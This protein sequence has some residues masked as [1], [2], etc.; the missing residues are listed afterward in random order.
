MKLSIIVAMTKDRVIGDKGN[1][2]WHIPEE[3]QLFRDVTMGHPVVM[4]RKTWESIP[5]KY[6][7]LEGRTNIVLSSKLKKEK[8][9]YVAETVEDAIEF[10]QPNDIYFIGGSKVYEAVLPCANELRISWIKKKYLGKT[11]FPEFDLNQWKPIKCDE[12]EEFVH[13]QYLK[14]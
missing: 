12:Y 13:V 14:K 6:R 8:G 2:P 7:P 1:M 11:K 5:E 10:C 3:L 9:I 4:G